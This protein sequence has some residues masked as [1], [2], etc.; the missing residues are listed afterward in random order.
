MSDKPN[1]TGRAGFVVV[2][3]EER[4]VQETVSK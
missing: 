1:E 2:V 4:L 3:G